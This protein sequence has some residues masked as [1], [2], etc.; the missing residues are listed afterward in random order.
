MSKAEP[1]N[2]RLWEP[3]E[4]LGLN[5]VHLDSWSISVSAKTMPGKALGVER[6]LRWRIKQAL[7]AA[8]IRIVGGLPQD[9]AEEAAPTR[10]RASPPRPRWP[11][12]P[13]R[14]R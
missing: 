10:R 6:E 8:G 9:A 11:I 3:V 14:R 1:W 13:P 7:D 5:E 4:V 2:E 12:P